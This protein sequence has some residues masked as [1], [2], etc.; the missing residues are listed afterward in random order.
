MTRMGTLPVSVINNLLVHVLR[1]EG[2]IIITQY[3]PCFSVHERGE[4]G[5]TG[6]CMKTIV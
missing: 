6:I 1:V 5:V 2:K 3:T 4:T